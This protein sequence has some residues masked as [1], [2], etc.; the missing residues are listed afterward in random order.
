MMWVIGSVI[1][2][3][4]LCWLFYASYSIGAGVY[5]KAL[6]RVRTE[7]KVVALTFD[8]GPDAI[9]TPVVLD[10]LKSYGVRATFFCIGEKAQQNE[11]IV[12]RLV[13]EGHLLGNHSW[14][15]SAFFPLFSGRK[16][17]EELQKTAQLLE[18]FAGR[19]VS[20]FRPPFGVTNPTIASVAK[21]LEYEVIGWNIRSL[22]T[23]SRDAGAVFL[24]IRKQICPG[25]IILLH[26]R[27]P[28]SGVLLEKVLQYLRTENYEVRR[29]DEMLDL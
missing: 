11:D 22:D 4:L 29:I 21:R 6:C 14:T 15:H 19:K 24:R 28:G 27:L 16:M 18:G 26:D 9:Y 12:R 5:V 2:A 10:L 23:C 1:L 8:D 13:E 7:R 25:A 17:Q 20:L 3:L